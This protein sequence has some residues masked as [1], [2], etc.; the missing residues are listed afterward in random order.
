MT[1]SSKISL[2]E[3]NRKL[4]DPNL[5]EQELQKYFLVDE[6]K[7]G[8]LN[9]VLEINRAE[10]TVPAN[11]EGQARSAALL[12]P[13]D[14]AMRTYRQNRDF[15]T[16][17]G[18]S[19]P[20]GDGRNLTREITSP[21]SCSVRLISGC[22]D[23]QVSLD[24]IGNGAFTAALISTWNHGRFNRDYVAF[25]R[26]IMKRLPSTQTPNHWHVGP[27]NPV[28]DAQTPFAI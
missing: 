26:A 18:A 9:P 5:S 27:R 2:E 12:M 19:T 17:L 10:V 14:V 28:Y 3:L 24:G 23:N 15:Y 4:A 25:H 20:H 8:P 7:S 22:Q 1:S 16:R 13:D 6:E 11:P 21:I